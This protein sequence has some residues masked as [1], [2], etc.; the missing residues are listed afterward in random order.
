M[1]SS[2]AYGLIILSSGLTQFELKKLTKIKVFGTIILENVPQ[3]I[4]QLLYASQRGI[5]QAVSIA[6]FA[7]MLSVTA[8]LLSYLIERNGD[9]L[10]PVEYYLTINCQRGSNKNHIKEYQSDEDEHD[11]VLTVKSHLSH[12]NLPLESV[13]PTSNANRNRLTAKEKQ[14]ILDNRGRRI[15]LGESLASLCKIQPK[16]IEIGATLVHNCGAIIHCVHMVYQSEIDIMQQELTED[17]ITVTP[18]F[19][20][21]Q[22]YLSLDKEVTD[23]LRDHF[24]LGMDF[25]VEYKDFA[26]MKK[27]TMTRKLSK[28]NDNNENNMLLKRMVTHSKLQG[29][30][31][32]VSAVK[33][34]FEDGD[35]G[36]DVKKERL[37]KIIEDEEKLQYTQQGGYSEINE[38]NDNN[39][40]LGVEMT[41]ILYEENNNTMNGEED[42]PFDKLNKKASTAL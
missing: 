12:K 21:K 36:L 9:D 6:F 26:G 40:N 24:K 5:T 20:T 16:N 29:D 32:I 41:S 10:K 23:L 8:T 33:K 31:N 34:Y 14:K 13:G 7:S 15:A 19:Y 42:D 11:G 22:L 17:G 37:L 2:N 35:D 28:D 39:N 3:L 18:N 27:R 30:G 38:R 25:D 4:L 1:V